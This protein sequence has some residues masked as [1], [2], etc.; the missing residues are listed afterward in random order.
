MVVLW[1]VNLTA[2]SRV[3]RNICELLRNALL[4]E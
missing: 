2:A 1:E 4:D 3:Q